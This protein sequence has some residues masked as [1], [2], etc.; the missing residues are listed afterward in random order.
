MRF[1]LLLTANLFCFLIGH[2]QERCLAIKHA[3]II[4]MDSPSPK[5][6]HTVVIAG[7]QIVKIGPS[8]IV[9]IPKGAHIINASG[10]YLIPGLWDTHVHL[11]KAGENSLILFI[12]NGITSVRDMGGD[13]TPVLQWKKEIA[14]GMRVGPRIKMA[15]PILEASS[16]V[17]RMKQEGTVEPVAR[18]RVGIPDSTMATALVDSV[19]NLGV[20][21][22][23]V[24]SVASSATYQAIAKVATNRGLMLTGHAVA[25]PDEMIE[26]GQRSIEHS[27]LPSL[28]ESLRESERKSLFKRLARVC[29]ILS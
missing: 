9:R 5:K 19:I 17:Q 23:K 25:S 11:A 7:N 20:D 16:N 28:N 6:D 14:A 15:G 27:F 4:D 13:P 29:F 12:A 24:R 22:L 8:P 10:Y 3:T 21:F 18:S 1:F 2:A 26:V